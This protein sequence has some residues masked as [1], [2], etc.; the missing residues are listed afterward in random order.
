MI[1]FTKLEINCDLDEN[2]TNELLKRNTNLNLFGY[3]DTSK[4]FHG[5]IN[6]NRFKIISTSKFNNSFRAH[7]YGKIYP[8]KN[9]TKIKMIMILHPITMLFMV[10]IFYS[11][12]A[13]LELLIMC[14]CMSL[15]FFWV[16]V[17]RTKSEINKV[18][19]D[20]IYSNKPTEFNKSLE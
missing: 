9:F 5:K 2:E 3:S 15:L 11:F 13:H 8:Y 10:Y 1:I 16:D 17:K 19:K 14:L 6:E 12:S 18:F 20:Y 4:Y 7:V